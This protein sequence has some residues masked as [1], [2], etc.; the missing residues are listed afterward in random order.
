MQGNRIS[1]LTEEFGEELV[2]PCGAFE[3]DVHGAFGF[4]LADDVEGDV[5]EH[6]EV[7]WAVVF[8]V[9]GVVLVHDHIEHPVE[10]ILDAPMGAGDVAE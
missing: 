4:F 5:A 1:N 2:V 7:V 9:A 3:F 6:G 8:S 10:A